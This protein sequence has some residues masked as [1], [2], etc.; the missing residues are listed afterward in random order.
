MSWKTC[1]NR[2]I[3]LRSETLPQFSCGFLPCAPRK[4][5]FS[6]GKCICLQE[7]KGMFLQE[8]ASFF[9]GKRIFL[10][11]C[12]KPFFL[13]N[14]LWGNKESCLGEKIR[15]CTT[16]GFLW[17]CLEIIL[18]NCPW[19]IAPTT[20]DIFGTLR[21]SLTT[22]EGPARHLDVSD[23]VSSD[24]VFFQGKGLKTP[25][26]DPPRNSPWNLFA[27]FPSD[28][29][30]SLFLTFLAGREVSPPQSSPEV[31]PSDPSNVKLNCYKHGNPKHA[32]VCMS[33]R[34]TMGRY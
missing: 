33:T 2:A 17:K 19:E 32:L 14:L 24:P 23:P 29:C 18:E 20:R 31:F 1:S 4:P 15:D 10:L 8:K 21:S 7:K 12:R 16:P 25:P 34:N 28:F 26:K 30:R 9:A 27:Q 5:Q 13:H 22:P 11:L 6:A 3:T